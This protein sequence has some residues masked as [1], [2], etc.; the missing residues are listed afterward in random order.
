MRKDPTTKRGDLPRAFKCTVLETP[1]ACRMCF[2]EQG[3][4]AF[5]LLDIGLDGW[6]VGAARVYPVVGCGRLV[7]TTMD[8][9][10]G[11]EQAIN[12]GLPDAVGIE[13][14]HSG[15]A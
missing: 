10:G 3:I 5:H 15:K 9:E 12:K 13:K 8:G 11:G 6:L 4:C 7:L 2:A 1:D 14:T